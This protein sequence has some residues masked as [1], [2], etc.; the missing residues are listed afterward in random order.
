MPNVGNTSNKLREVHR[1]SNMSRNNDQFLP[2]TDTVYLRET[3]VGSI[4]GTYTYFMP[5]ELGH[6]IE[7][8]S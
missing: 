7:T 5:W 2:K 3:N 1:G 4:A 6:R 8:V